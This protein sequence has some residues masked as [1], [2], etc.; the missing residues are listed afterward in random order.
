MKAN[1]KRCSD[2]HQNTVLVP[3]TVRSTPFWTKKTA[4]IRTK[5]LIRYRARTPPNNTELGKLDVLNKM[6]A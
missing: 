2:L 3:I 4:A 1:I 5:N 6:L